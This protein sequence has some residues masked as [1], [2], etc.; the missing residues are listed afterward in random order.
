[1]IR[2]GVTGGIGSGKST[3]CHEWE[4]LGAFVVYA[5]D[6]AKE[7]MVSDP[8]LIHEIKKTFGKASYHSDGN[9]NRAHLAEEAFE[10]NR[11]EELNALVHPVLWHHID[12][13]TEAKEKEGIDIFV[14]EAALLLKNGRPEN[15]DQVVLLLADEERRIDRVVG[16]DHTEEHKVKERIDKQDSFE[17][18]KHLA[19]FVITN[20]GSL[21]D[22]K[23]QARTLFRTLKE[24]T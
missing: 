12:K 13:L 24:E 1:M 15:I 3:L 14:K 7:L 21:S 17:D 4:K 10:K 2:V 20:D 5:D 8:K 22:L 19:D 16:R 6:I 11:V 18:L 23:Q 9:L